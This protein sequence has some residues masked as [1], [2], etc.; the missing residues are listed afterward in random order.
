MFHN[1]NPYCMTSLMTSNQ[2]FS[3]MAFNMLS[4]ICINTIA[5]MII[6]SFL[7][8]KITSKTNNQSLATHA[9]QPIKTVST[10]PAETIK[11]VPTTPAI[12]SFTCPCCNNT[13]SDRIKYGKEFNGEWFCGD[14]CNTMYTTR[15][16]YAKQFAQQSTV[17]FLPANPAFVTVFPLKVIPGR[18]SSDGIKFIF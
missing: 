15:Q 1:T 7:Y 11:T 9:E 3:I 12:C 13:Y 17:S 14:T 5:I 2:S 4:T 18:Y 16:Q 8:Q 10:T 6:I